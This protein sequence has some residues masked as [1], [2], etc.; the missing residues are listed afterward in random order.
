MTKL[1]SFFCV[2]LLAVV[3]F[4]CGDDDDDGGSKGTKP[5]AAQLA[6][7]EG[8][9]DESGEMAT[10][11]DC[12]VSTY[13]QC[14][15]TQCASNYE[16]C[17]GSG[18]KSGSIGGRCEEFMNCAL[19]SPDPC[20]ATDCAPSDDCAACMFEIASCVLSSSCELPSCATGGEQPSPG[21][22]PGG[23]GGGCAA[24]MACCNSLSGDDQSTCQSSLDGS[25]GLDIVCDATLSIY[26]AAGSCP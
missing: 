13:S 10:P 12:D 9:P 15:E 11:A 8:C 18:Y 16:A 1:S 26:Q 20:K 14:V 7:G 25:M 21:D 17:L 2:S 23:T 3:P 4:A 19:N 22:V 5:T 24:L 6:S